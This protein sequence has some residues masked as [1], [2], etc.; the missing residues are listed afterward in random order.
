MIAMKIGIVGLGL[1]GGSLG[2]EFVRQG[3]QVWGV[4]RQPD[5]CAEAISRQ[6]VHF[7]STDLGSLA[8][9]SLEMV[10][11][12]TPIPSVLP[13]ISQLA[14]RL[15]PRATI[16]DVASV[17]AP[18]VDAA[19]QIWPDFIG[20]HPMA[21]T[22]EQGIQAAVLGLFQDRPYVI[23]PT[24]STPTIAIERLQTLV[25][26]LGSRLVLCQPAQHDQ[27]VAWISHL[28]VMISASLIAAC[29]QSADAETLRLAQQ[30]AS[31]GFRD[32]SRVGA[33]N[34]D[35]GVA[36]AQF[37]RDALLKTLSH[38]QNSLSDLIYMIEQERWAELQQ[39]LL[40]TQQDRQHFMQS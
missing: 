19:L 12:C 27:A 29:A 14:V 33:G 24:A 37:N 9:V 23:T 2:L 5:T 31:S 17:K 28:P 34:P 40:Q 38:Y 35:L 26:Q 6:A 16:T 15:S 1:I 39:R 30:L 20:G 25:T 21:G 8:A 36:M 13:T 3:H 32:T 7:A 18:I 4:S 22:A 10:F 11:V